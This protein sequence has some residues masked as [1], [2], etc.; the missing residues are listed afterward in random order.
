[1]SDKGIYMLDEKQKDTDRFIRQR[2]NLIAIS[3]TLIFYK[4]AQLEIETVGFLGNTIKVGSPDKILSILFVF[5]VYFLWRYYTACND[6]KGLNTVKNA[7][8]WQ[9]VDFLKIYFKEKYLE[10]NREPYFTINRFSVVFTRDYNGPMSE[11]III[12]WRYRWLL[13]RSFFYVIFHTSHF[14]EYIVPYVLAI[15]AFAMTIGAFFP[16]PMY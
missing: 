12:R 2:R 14:S 4:L 11:D 1:M 16:S 13:T 10:N 15:L 8:V 5:F 9:A 3:L 7:C 6:V